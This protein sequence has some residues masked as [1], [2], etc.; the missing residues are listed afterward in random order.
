MPL[1]GSLTLEGLLL[2]EGRQLVLRIDDGGLWRIEAGQAAR[3]LLGRRVLVVGTRDGFD[4]VAARRI[5]LAAPR[6]SGS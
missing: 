5:A 1:G 6:T 4:L 2:A 3:K